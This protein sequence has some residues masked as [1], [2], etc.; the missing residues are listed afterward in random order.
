VVDGLVVEEVGGDDLSDDL[1]EEF[2]PEVLGGDLL[3][4]L[5]RDNDGVDSDGDHGTVVLLVLNGDLGLGVR[6][7]P[8]KRLVSSGNSH[9][10]VELVGEDDR[11]GHELLGLVGSVSE[12]G[13]TEGSARGEIEKGRKGCERMGRQKG[14]RQRTSQSAIVLVSRL[15]DEQVIGERRT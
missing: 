2:L 6:S 3:G 14:M 15:T 8:C 11:E 1:L 7:E 12:P 13:R 4:V 9:G 5:G 10:G